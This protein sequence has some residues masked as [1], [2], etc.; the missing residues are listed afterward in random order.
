VDKV[1]RLA[2]LG[3]TGSIGRQTL[4]VVRAH[5]DRFS[6][7]G[8]AGGAN[9]DLLRQQASEF[10]PL[11]LASPKL[12]SA[13]AAA[14]GC[15]LVSLEE[16]AAAPETD[17]VV[18][19]TAGKA[20]LLPTLAAIR[21][22]KEVALANKESLV[23][24]GEIVMAEARARGVTIRPIDSE[25]SAIW[26]CLWGEHPETVARL[27]LTASGGAFRDYSPEQLALVTP[28]EALRHPTWLMGPKVTVDSATLMNKGLEI[29]EAH[30][31]FGLAYNQIEVILHRESIVHAIVEFIDGSCKAQLSP[32]DM[33]L[34]IQCALAYPERPPSPFPRLNPRQLGH[35]T[36][37]PVDLQRYPCLAL[38]RQ[39]GE[40]GGTYPA[41][42]SA[43]DEVAVDLFLAGQLPFLAISDLVAAVLDRHVSTPHP[44]LEEIL[45]ADAWARAMAR[46]L[47]L[48]G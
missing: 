30:W 47:A 9:L 12:D 10:R 28:Q 13:T 15:R 38:A 40:A 21:A 11:L 45:A 4:E 29:M 36:F 39:A 26:Q 35:L 18:V 8:L 7:V 27:F 17:L 24:A 3:S 33:R 16:M 20:G 22:G 34:P 37:G 46:Q 14:L 48:P 43:A 5:P 19:A 44:G 41:V 31:L 6:V 32:P 42:L 1:K 2:I 25:H 23:I